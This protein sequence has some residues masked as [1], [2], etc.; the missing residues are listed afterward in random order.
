MLHCV[1]KTTFLSGVYKHS[2]TVYYG[3]VAGCVHLGGG[4]Q[5]DSGKFVLTS[6]SILG[7]ILGKQRH[8]NKKHSEFHYFKMIKSKTLIV[9]WRTYPMDK[10][11]NCPGPRRSGG[12][13]ASGALLELG[14]VDQSTFDA[15][16]KSSSDN[17]K[18]NSNVYMVMEKYKYGALSQ[19]GPH[20]SQPKQ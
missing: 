9:Q 3:V 6:L 20:L 12:P 8:S 17:K 13:R 5:V 7:Q 10:R 16:R 4:Q 14:P 19:V 15:E 18:Y 2:V 11:D 1:K